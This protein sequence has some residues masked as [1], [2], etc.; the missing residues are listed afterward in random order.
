MVKI[1]GIKTRATPKPTIRKSSRK[2]TP[3][4]AFV[5]Q[6]T[7]T[8]TRGKTPRKPPRKTSGKTPGN[9][10]GN[11]LVKTPGKQYKNKRL[12]LSQLIKKTGYPTFKPQL[13]LA[14]ELEKIMPRGEIDNYLSKI[15]Q[16]TGSINE[17]FTNIIHYIK[18]ERLVLTEEIII[19]TVTMSVKKVMLELFDDI[20]SGK[21]TSDNIKGPK[22]GRNLLD[23][24]TPAAKAE[25]RAYL[26]SDKMREFMTSTVFGQFTPMLNKAMGVD[27]RKYNANQKVMPGASQSAIDSHAK[28][29][30]EAET[31][32]TEYLWRD[33]IEKKAVGPPTR[34]CNSVIRNKTEAQTEARMCYLCGTE[35]LTEHGLHCEHILPILLAVTSFSLAPNKKLTYNQTELLKYEY[36]WSHGCC[37][38]PS[39]N[40]I[41]IIKIHPI[42]QTWVEDHAKI[43]EIANNLIANAI[44]KP[45]ECYATDLA[46]SIK[47]ITFVATQ[48]CKVLNSI[49]SEFVADDNK[50]GGVSSGVPNELQIHRRILCD[51][52]G[53]TKLLCAVADNFEYIL[54]GFNKP[55][56]EG[57]TWVGNNTVGGGRDGNYI[58]KGGSQ[59]PDG[60][61][62]I[63]DIQGHI[64]PIEKKTTQPPQETSKL[65]TPNRETPTQETPTQERPT[66]ETPEEYEYTEE[67]MKLME[68]SIVPSREIM[69][70]IENTAIKYLENYD[71]DTYKTTKTTDDNTEFDI[72]KVDSDKIKQR[73]G[74]YTKNKKRKKSKK[75]RRKKS[76]R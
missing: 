19:N 51:L 66:Q 45:R 26:G 42:S 75:T 59:S 21:Y 53:K 28:N 18:G 29:I 41:T 31:K 23:E 27:L 58:N 54:L 68:E 52:L 24:M 14:S 56:D 15:S 71:P 69:K 47:I 61:E 57:S 64:E 13:G 7:T 12:T 44:A 70:I 5:F 35:M 46:T 36:L 17:L 37:N 55:A 50:L 60:V 63:G 1:R 48:L 2:R 11:T 33:I 34:Q 49:E 20:V 8:K 10:S 43:K 39:K 25:R 4:V 40:D 16:N 76:K 22:S 3:S 9:T 32:K 73:G 74:K 38:T 62:H 30:E 67:E 72:V 65:N 6:Q